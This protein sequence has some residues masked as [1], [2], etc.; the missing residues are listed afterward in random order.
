METKPNPLALRK[1]KQ[2]TALDEAEAEELFGKLY[3]L[4]GERDAPRLLMLDTPYQAQ[5]ARYIMGS[6]KGELEHYKTSHKLQDRIY[7]FGMRWPGQSLGHRVAA[8]FRGEWIRS[9]HPNYPEFG[10]QQAIQS[11]GARTGSMIAKPS[12][13]GQ[14]DMWS[15]EAAT[16][17]IG[18]IA[19]RLAELVGVWFA[20]KKVVIA[21]RK[22][23]K[24]I[25]DGEDLPHN[26]TG[27]AVVW[28]TELDKNQETY[29]WHGIKIEKADLPAWRG[30]REAVEE[31]VPSQLYWRCYDIAPNGKLTGIYGQEQQMALSP[32]A[33][34][35]A[36]RRDQPPHTV[37]GRR[38]SC[39]YYA[40]PTLEE[41]QKEFGSGYIYALVEVLG[42]VLICQNGVRCE[43][44]RLVG[45]APS[46][47]SGDNFIIE[48]TAKR[49]GVPFYS[50]PDEMEEI[51]IPE[52]EAV[53][54]MRRMS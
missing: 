5:N 21:S 38:C 19:L 34:C 18:K 54:R 20:Y 13:W 39:G 44:I 2:E 25:V 52:W 3:E 7:G 45:I 37:P 8:A 35:S 27:P 12:C 26:E 51:A 47:E 24:I 41:A 30:E 46:S 6:P 29:F 17:E 43:Q 16:S 36:G 11:L 23:T 49:L 14:F 40:L 15:E 10:L 4:L 53:Q 42:E 48:E 1:G 31:E 50:S 9:R 28:Q 32:L 22:P 33:T